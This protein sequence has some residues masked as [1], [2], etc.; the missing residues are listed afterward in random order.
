MMLSA[1]AEEVV[2]PSVVV[3]EID[4]VPVV[5]LLPEITPVDVFSD[6]PLDG[7]PVHE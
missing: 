3:H 1:A 6:S 7:K 4:T 2:T 5:G